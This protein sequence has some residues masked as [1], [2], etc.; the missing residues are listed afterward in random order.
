MDP[1]LFSP[2]IISIIGIRSQ[3]RFCL[4]PCFSLPNSLL[5]NRSI[6]FFFYVCLL[7]R[8]SYFF[9]IFQYPFSVTRPFYV[10]E[11][12]FRFAFARHPHYRLRNRFFSPR[13]S[14]SNSLLFVSPEFAFVSLFSFPFSTFF[15]H[16]SLSYSLLLIINNFAFDFLINFCS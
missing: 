14:F 16:F 9:Y 8:F 4:F 3:N 1:F 12:A 13:N 6:S 11:F 5:F 2:I 7:S 15:I 10:H